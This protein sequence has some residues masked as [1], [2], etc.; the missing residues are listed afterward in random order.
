MATLFILKLLVVAV[1]V[2]IVTANLT[3][4]QIKN[5]EDYHNHYRMTTKP[6]AANMEFM[7]S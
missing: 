4:E 5:I 1:L 7:V 3:K 6:S 2:G